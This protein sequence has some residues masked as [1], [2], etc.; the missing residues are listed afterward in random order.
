MK[1]LMMLVAVLG[2]SSTMTFAQDATPAKAEKHGKKHHKMEK[3]AE[4]K[5][6]AK[7]EPAKVEAAKPAPAAKA[8]K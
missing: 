3:K 1:K 7:A 8:K 6:D 5:A 4:A 2:L